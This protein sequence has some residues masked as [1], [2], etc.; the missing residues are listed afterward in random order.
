MIVHAEVDRVCNLHGM[1]DFGQGPIVVLEL[2]IRVREG[3]SSC[4]VAVRREIR[5]SEVDPFRASRNSEVNSMG[6]SKFLRL[7]FRIKCKCKHQI[8]ACEDP[9]VSCSPL[10]P[11]YEIAESHFAHFVK[12]HFSHTGHEVGN[13]GCLQQLEVS[14]KIFLGNVGTS[15]W[16][17]RPFSVGGILSQSMKLQGEVDLSISEKVPWPPLNL[18]LNVRRR[19]K[20]DTVSSKFRFIGRDLPVPV[21]VIQISQSH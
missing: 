6:L 3:L 21:V 7:L 17:K 13:S 12:E 19:V 15:T 8:F 20:H 2:D 11:V 4:R 14:P 1:N 5:C 9:V 16:Y 18:I 10:V